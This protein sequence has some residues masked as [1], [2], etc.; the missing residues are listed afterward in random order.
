[1][2]IEYVYW[3]D[4]IYELSITRK[5]RIKNKFIRNNRRVEDWSQIFRLKVDQRSHRTDLLITERR[6]HL[7]RT[8][9]LPQAAFPWWRPNLIDAFQLQSIAKPKWSHY[10][11]QLFF[12]DHLLSN[13]KWSFIGRLSS[14]WMA[15]P[16][17]FVFLKVT[18][19]SLFKYQLISFF[20][21]L[22][23]KP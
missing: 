20:S 9:R 23:P 7:S 10:Q 3:D 12:D 5:D 2:S 1:M 22:V 8:V 16:P 15:G 14:Y 11:S 19:W 21:H 17:A 18:G 6:S 4:E 13:P